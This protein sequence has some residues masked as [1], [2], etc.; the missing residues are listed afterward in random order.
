MNKM[1]QVVA[2]FLKNQVYLILHKLYEH[3]GKTD[4]VLIQTSDFILQPKED[5][6]AHNVKCTKG[7]QIVDNIFLGFVLDFCLGRC[8]FSG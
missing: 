1:L 5:K 8:C 6:R 3:S 7:E 2:V 4:K